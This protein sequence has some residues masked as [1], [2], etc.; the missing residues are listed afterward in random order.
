MSVLIFWLLL[1][2]QKL[3]LLLLLCSN[4]LT[5]SETLRHAGEGRRRSSRSTVT[6][7]LNSCTRSETLLQ[8]GDF[9]E[10]G[11]ELSTKVSD[12]GSSLVGDEQPPFLP[13]SELSCLITLPESFPLFVMSAID[14]RCIR[15]LNFP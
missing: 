2:L 5:R 3:K 4:T 8:A 14:H 11:P 12:P 15:S 13:E 10:I 9:I 1:K 6:A 7:G